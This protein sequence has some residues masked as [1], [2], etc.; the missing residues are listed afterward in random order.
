MIKR[1]ITPLGYKAVRADEIDSPDTITH[2]ISEYLFKSPLAIADLTNLNPNVFYELG[3]RHTFEQKLPVIHIA[4]KGTKLPFDLNQ[5]NV[6][7]YD[8][9]DL[10]SAYEATDKIVKFIENIES[11][12]KKL[13]TPLNQ[14]LSQIRTPITPEVVKHEYQWL[15]DM[16]E[17]K[18]PILP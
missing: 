8:L 3:A 2:N 11:N 17:K 5:V 13:D 9:S 1:T 15:L 14:S 10:D 16:L 12:K 4:E 18:K 7:F 6:I